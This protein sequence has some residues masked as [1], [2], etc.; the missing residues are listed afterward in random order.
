MENSLYYIYISY[1]FIERKRD[2]ML[3]EL[4]DKSKVVKLEDMKKGD[5][6]FT[7]Y[8]DHGNYVYVVFDSYEIDGSWV[9]IKGT[10]ISRNGD[11]LNKEWVGFGGNY[12][13]NV[14]GKVIL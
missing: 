2:N 9:R 1:F 14:V 11:V 8:G 7:E 6:F 13:Y 5:I 12:Y 3:V 4:F 10:H